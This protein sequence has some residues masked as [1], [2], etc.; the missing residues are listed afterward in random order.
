MI[1]INN[2]SV[3]YLGINVTKWCK[4]TEELDLRK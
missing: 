3:H 1:H 4:K 2:K